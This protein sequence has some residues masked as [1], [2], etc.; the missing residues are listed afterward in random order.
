MAIIKSII[1]TDLYKLTQMWAVIC[2]FPELKV[3]YK[4]IDRNNNIYPKGFAADLVYEIQTMAELSLTTSEAIFLKSIRYFPQIYIDLLKGFKLDPS[5]IHVSQ[6]DEGHLEIGIEGYW[7]RTIYWE[8]MLLALIS[9]LYFKK[10]GQEVDIHQEDLQI[11]DI[12]KTKLLG[13]HG[14]HHADFGT[15]RRYSFEN[16]ERIVKLFRKEGNG[17]FVGTSNVHLA[18]TY[19]LRPIGTMAHE[20]IMVHGAIYGYKQANPL[21]FKNWTDIYKGDLGIALTDTFTTDVFFR[22]FDMKDAKLFDGVRHDSGSPYAFRDKTCGKY[23][24]LGIDPMSK[25]IVFSNALT[26]EESINIKKDCIGHIK[27]S[28]GIGTHL[29]NDVGVKPL[30][31]VIKISDVFINGSWVPTVKLSDDVGKNTGD[32]KEVELCKEILRVK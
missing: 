6:D 16:Q 1:D 2:K 28:A 8:V 30:N 10:T 3:R 5:E 26:V 25:A 7:Y 20:W 17:F 18:K 12:S 15:R 21:S 14:M 11:K 24:D 13:E 27:S 19:N 32:P 29:S 31:I 23:D 4:F 9:E 22:S